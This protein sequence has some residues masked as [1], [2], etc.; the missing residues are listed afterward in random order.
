MLKNKARRAFAWAAL[1]VPA[2]IVFSEGYAA[3]PDGN[4]TADLCRKGCLQTYE[5]YKKAGA[6]VSFIEVCVA[7]CK[8]GWVLKSESEIPG[9]CRETCDKFLATVPG[10][11]NPQALKKCLENCQRDGRRMLDRQRQGGATGPPTSKQ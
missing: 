11:K 1:V 3:S 2:F 4:Q 6:T 10:R 5:A 8:K 9:Y 7:Q